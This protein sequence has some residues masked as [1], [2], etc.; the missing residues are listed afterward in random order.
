[1]KTAA[2][3]PKTDLLGLPIPQLEDYLEGLGEKRFHA[4][5]VAEWIYKRKVFDFS[6]MTN[7]SKSLRQKLVE[8]GTVSGLT[9]EKRRV[10]RRDGTAKVLF[11]S[12]DGALVESVF[13]PHES[14]ATACIS[15]QV[16]CGMGCRFCAS[17][18][19]GLARNLSSAEILAQ[20]L[21]LE[22]DQGRELDNLVYMGMGEPLHNWEAVAASI[23]VLTDS[24][25]RGWT[26]RKITLSTCGLAPGIRKLAESGIKARL[27]VSLHAADDQTRS[28]LMPVNDRH[29]LKELL[30]ACAFYQQ[31][32]G[33]QITFEV[34]LFKGINDSLDQARLMARRLKSL[35]C[36][37]NL[38]PYNPVEGLDFHPP[39]F[40][41]GLR[42]PDRPKKR[43]LGG[44]AAH[45]KR[46]GHR[47]GLRPIEE[48][49]GLP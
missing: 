48:K 35:A 4:R 1:M 23:S 14:R 12:A 5:Q 17:G 22:Q 19:N 38:I 49:A 39:D 2:I 3:D 33:L 25:A 6:K 8:L 13:L 16:G 40:R 21:G 47:R 37:V 44:H 26:G 32:T 24:K 27:A 30:A 36:K 46:R 41:H 20:V 7:L 10:S 34:I 28:R 18:L 15:T 45:G 42:L 9:I 29:P 43:G 11:K 31:A